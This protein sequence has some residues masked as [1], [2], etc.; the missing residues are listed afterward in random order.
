MFQI[1]QLGNLG[2]LVSHPVRLPQILQDIRP[3]PGLYYPSLLAYMY[4]PSLGLYCHS[5]LASVHYPSLDLY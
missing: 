3:S 4:S 2:A 1:P 5:L